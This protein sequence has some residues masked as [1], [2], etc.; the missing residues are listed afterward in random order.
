[1]SGGP[2]AGRGAEGGERKRR[3]LPPKRGGKTTMD[4]EHDPLIIAL[5]LD[6]RSRLLQVVRE[7]RGGVKTLKLGLEAYTRFG[8]FLFGEVREMGFKVFADLKLHDIP[9]TVAG[10]VRALVGWGVSMLTLH[11]LGGRKMM[12]A[13]VEAAHGEADRLGVPAP[14][15]LGVTVLTSLDGGTLRELGCPEETG[16]WVTRLGVLGMDCGLDGLVCSALEVGE[17]R[18]RLGREA[19]LVTPGIRL[20]GGE[21]HDQARTATPAE[22][23]EAGADYIVVGRPVTQAAR[24]REALEELRR[25]I[26]EGGVGR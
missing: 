21:A 17:L 12:E 10:A 4:R 26:G 7:L 16:E 24:P 22:A 9:N 1:M 20:P 15:V 25:A 23:L 5:D 3:D 14:L 2:P 11:V 8:P 13:G 18:R 6:D 19:V